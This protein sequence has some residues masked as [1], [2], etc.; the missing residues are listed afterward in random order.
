MRAFL[1]TVA[2]VLIAFVVKVDLTEGTLSLAAFYPKDGQNTLC[3]DQRE[4]AYITVQTIQG[5]TIHSLFALHPAKM[6]MTFPERLELFYQ[7]NPHL[8]LQ[9]LVPGENIKLPLSFEFE[10][11]CGK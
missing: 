1:L 9:A 2:I 8:Q 4:P 10:N 11:A 6:P 5:D 7:L 3:E